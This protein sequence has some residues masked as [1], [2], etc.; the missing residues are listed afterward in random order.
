[1]MRS[2]LLDAFFHQL[3]FR[4]LSRYASVVSKAPDSRLKSLREEGTDRFSGELSIV[5]V[6]NQIRL[7][8]SNPKMPRKPE[9]F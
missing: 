2:S 1:M 3:P 4:M 7:F 9:S 6:V 8:S 5:L